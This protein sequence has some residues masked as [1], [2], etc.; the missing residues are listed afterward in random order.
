MGS[1]SIMTQREANSWFEG[2]PIEMSVKYA[3]VIKTM[4][5]IG[6]YTPLLPLISISGIVGLILT[7][8]MD[9]VYF[10]INI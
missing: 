5:F 9:K 7:Y 3:H 6:F 4:W 8:W 10:K 1:D 2:G